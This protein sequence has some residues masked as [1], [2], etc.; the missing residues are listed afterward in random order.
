MDLQTINQELNKRFLATLPE[1]YKRR[2]VVWYDEEKEFEDQIG[3]LELQDAKV[4]CVTG[5]NYFEIKK[6][7]AVD[8][9]NQNFLLYNICKIGS[10]FLYL[11]FPYLLC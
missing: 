3:E 6:R 4:L 5:N 7:L 1:F 2:I 8:E 10:F 9:P 11:Y